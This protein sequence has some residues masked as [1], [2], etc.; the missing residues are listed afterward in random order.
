M[1]VQHPP[2]T[3][4]REQINSLLQD[5]AQDSDE[6]HDFAREVIV[7]CNAELAKRAVQAPAQGASWKPISTAPRDGRN[8][9][10]RFG[11]DGSSQ[12]KYVSGLPYPWKFVD[13]DNGVTWLINHAVDGPGGPSHWADFP[14]FHK[15]QLAAPAVPNPINEG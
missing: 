4:T 13:T 14:E 6:M 1:C 10:L 15:A 5:T 8:I 2:I 9:L 3:L 11:S 12:G 7:L